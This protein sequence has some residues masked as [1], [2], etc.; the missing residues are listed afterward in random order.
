VSGYFG[1]ERLAKRFAQIAI[2]G[3]CFVDIQCIKHKCL[4]LEVKKSRTPVYSEDL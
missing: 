2:V 3:D 1:D 4:P